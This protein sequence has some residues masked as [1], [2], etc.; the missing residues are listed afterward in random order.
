M[1]TLEYADDG[2]GMDHDTLGKLFDPFFTT[3]R[4]S[5]GSGLGAHILY[6]LATGALGGSV[7]VESA[8]GKGLQYC[9]KF[10]RS[11]RVEKQAAAALA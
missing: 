9:L 4:G 1:V 3:K 7:R 10:P 11:L 8:P 2:I 6:N 5:G